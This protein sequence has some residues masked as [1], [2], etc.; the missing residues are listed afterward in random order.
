MNEL[1]KYMSLAIEEAK[2]AKEIDEVPIGAI[3]VKD[4]KVISRAHNLREHKND[5]TSHAEIECIKKASKKLK[6]WQLID[7]DL[8][9]TIEPCIMCGGAI[10]QAHIRRVI[11]GSPDPKGGAFG[12]VIDITKLNNINHKPEVISG[13]LKEDTSS[14]VKNYFKEKRNKK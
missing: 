13:I 10:A 6:D 7:C 3:L 4:N 8:Y 1:E 11:Y 12:S 9:V 14:L 5:I 2:K